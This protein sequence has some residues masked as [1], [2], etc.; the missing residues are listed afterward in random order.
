MVVLDSMKGITT[1]IMNMRRT[2]H[3]PGIEFGD[4]QPKAQRRFRDGV[5][6]W[7]V[8]WTCYQILIRRKLHVGDERPSNDKKGLADLLE[9]HPDLVDKFGNAALNLLDRLGRPAHANDFKHP[10]RDDDDDESPSP[11]P[12]ED[13]DEADDEVDEEDFGPLAGPSLAWKI[14]IGSLLFAVATVCLTVGVCLGVRMASRSSALP[15]Q[16]LLQAS[17]REML[18]APAAAA[19]M[20]TR[21][22]SYQEV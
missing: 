10:R 8:P 22:T 13:D 7:T 3:H 21:L 6:E 18:P 14:A 9:Q 19:T 20:D 11:P 17:G 4:S 5:Q 2:G 12:K 15:T 16:P 1:R